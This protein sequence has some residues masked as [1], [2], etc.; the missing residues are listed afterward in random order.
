MRRI[1]FLFDRV[2]HYHKPLFQRLEAELANAGYELY[3]LSGK[4]KSRTLGRV[5]L[6]SAVIRN[7]IEFDLIEIPIG[8]FTLRYQRGVARTISKLSPCIVVTMCHSGTASEWQLIHLK[9]SCGFKLVAWQCG[10]EFNPIG[11]KQWVLNLFVP[12]FDHHLAYHTNAQRYAIAHGAHAEQITVMHNTINEAAI[13][14]LPKHE[15]RAIVERHWPAITGKKIILYVGAILE[16]KRLE[17]VFDAMDLLQRKDAIFV[18][19]GDGPHLQKIKQK[20]RDRKDFVCT[21]Q[22][23][24]GVGPYFDSGDVFVLPGTGGLAINEAMAHG[25]PVVAGYADGS[26]DDLVVD[27]KNGYRLRSGTPHELAKRLDDVLGDDVIALTMGATGRSMIHGDLSFERFIA[28]VI[29]VLT[30]PQLNREEL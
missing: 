11:L 14:S 13:V 20:F 15:A 5:A 6:K 2:M 1:V 21:G 29:G 8:S 23:V 22:T 3:L 19:V 16:E 28:R 9:K 18:M 10:Y 30:S 26:T 24:D 25:L 7:Q 17:L 4:E 27:D 12:N